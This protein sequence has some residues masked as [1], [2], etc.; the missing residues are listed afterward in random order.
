MRWSG[1]ANGARIWYLSGD[2]A[3]LRDVV[4]IINR[5]RKQLARLENEAAK[6]RAELD[7]I[8]DAVVGSDVPATDW[9]LVRRRPKRK[10]S[11]TA[12]AIDVLDQN[13]QPTHVDQMIEA[14]A[15][16]M[17]EHVKKTTLVSTLARLSKQRDTFYRSGS[18]TYGLLK[19]PKEKERAAG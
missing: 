12:W 4:G 17:G 8:R 11:V 19:W 15:A 14:I 10:G 7:T 6:L 2:M 3:P 16:K 13:H 18:N 9:T 1:V 5:K